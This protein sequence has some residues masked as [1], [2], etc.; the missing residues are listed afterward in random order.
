MYM[1]H[2]NSYDFKHSQ[3]IKNISEVHSIHNPHAFWTGTIN[4]KKDNNNTD[5]KIAII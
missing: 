2:Y 5:T 1:Y 3:R 4:L